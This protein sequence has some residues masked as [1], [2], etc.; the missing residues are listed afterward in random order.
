MAEDII[1]HTSKEY[2]TNYFRLVMLTMKEGTK[3]IEKTVVDRLPR[4]QTLHAL[5]QQR[6]SKLRSLTKVFN[7]DQLEVLYPPT[8]N[9]DLSKID[10]TLWYS[11]A[12]NLITLPKR[13]VVNWDKKPVPGEDEWYHDIIRI[14]R[15]RNILCH[16]KRPELDTVTFKEL[17]DY[18]SGAL[19]RLK[20]NI[21]FQKYR[22]AEYDREAARGYE[23]QVK[24]QVLQEMN[25]VLRAGLAERRN[26]VAVAVVIGILILI[27]IAVT[28]T[29]V[30]FQLRKVTFCGQGKRSEVI[31]PLGT[32]TI[33]PREGWQARPP[34]E[35]LDPLAIPVGIVEYTHTADVTQCTDCCRQVY[36]IQYLHMNYRGWSDIGYHYLIDSS[37]LVYEGRPP[38][39]MPA[40]VYGWN[41]K[42]ISIALLGNFMHEIPKDATLNAF[43]VLIQHLIQRDKVAHNFS[44]YAMC[45]LSYNYTDSP[46]RNLYDAISKNTGDYESFRH[47]AHRPEGMCFFNHSHH[48]GIFEDYNY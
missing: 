22:D 14:R 45:E 47:V 12:R 36:N 6:E 1:M 26:I 23:I 30:Y 35:P 38:D 7:F 11:L 42:I 28:T 19:G 25:N 17:W 4:G 27:L 18:V 34:S 31:D 37:G 15:T 2:E 33:M 24:D 43:D 5:L 16:L 39:K 29:V 9:C 41:R 8:G 20:P 13:P 48:N 10:M 3:A 21:R 44:L 32:L 46:G 40:S